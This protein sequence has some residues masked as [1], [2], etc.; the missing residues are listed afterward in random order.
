MLDLEHPPFLDVYTRQDTSP[1][2]SILSCHY[3]LF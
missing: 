1:E 3:F 2:K